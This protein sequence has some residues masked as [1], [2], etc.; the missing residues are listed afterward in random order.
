MYALARELKT[1]CSSLIR[2]A[3]KFGHHYK[4]HMS[5]VSDADEMFIKQ[6][7]KLSTGATAPPPKKE[8]ITR[9]KKA[10]GTASPA[11][12][13]GTYTSSAPPG[14]GAET[15]PAARPAEPIA[16]A[17]VTKAVITF[18]VPRAA[19]AAGGGSTGGGG[20]STATAPA[21][22][23]TGEDDGDRRG[24]GKGKGKGRDRGDRGGRDDER[25]A[26]RG[27]F[28]NRVGIQKRT[29]IG[30]AP[31]AK[32]TQGPTKAEIELPATVKD[33]CAAFGVKSD[34]VIQTLFQQGVM[35]RIN[36]FITRDEIE[37]LAIEF[38]VEVTIKDAQDHEAQLDKDLQELATRGIDTGDQDLVLRP[39]VVT[40]LGH[41]DH[42]KTSLLDRI[43]ESDV[44]GG[45]AGGI[46]QHIGAS[47]VFMPD[48]RSI[49][50]LDTPG[51]EAFTAMRARGAKIT[52]IVV[53]VVAAD[54]G[55]MP[56]TLE[57]IAHAK[58]ANVPI[59]VALNKSDRPE[60]NPMKVKGQLAEN[61]LTPTGDWGGDVEVIPTSAHPS[62]PFGI[63]DLLETILLQA[64][65]MELKA[66]PKR[67][68]TGAI[69]ESRKDPEEGVTATVLVRDGTLRPGDYGI[70]GNATGRVR[71]MFDDKGGVVEAAGPGTPVRVLG[72]EDP[73]EPGETF[74]VGTADDRKTMTRIATQKWNRTKILDMAS[75]AQQRSQTGIID[76]IDASKINEVR[77]VVKADTQGSCE[78]LKQVLNKLTGDE[79]RVNLI[80]IAVG[81]ITESDVALAATP[82]TSPTLLVGFHVIADPKAA[83]KADQDGVTMRTFRVIYELTAYIKKIMEGELAPE[84]IEVTL[85]TAE[86]RKT[87]FSSKVGT[88]AGCIVQK[89]TVNRNSRLRIY[90][91]N[92]EISPPD[93]YGLQS[94]KRLNDDAREVRE[95]MECGMVIENYDGVQEGDILR[96]FKI[97]EKARKFDD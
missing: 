92:I 86:V 89:G 40:M 43:R 48:G 85:A 96:F 75:K 87:F 65:V 77:L 84:E 41:V 17:K 93:G 25:G 53:L 21:P 79:V 27:R 34:R 9:H 73:P 14:R 11:A 8:I 50:F 36:D 23:D 60:A 13:S 54:D 51:H 6:A 45:E 80:H 55:V 90:R 30:S 95:G 38:E 74:Y 24:K 20:G 78:V 1:D 44:A 58:A 94:L 62:K 83:A 2:M 7:Y 22:T 31:Q 88:I 12:A 15:R 70:A 32:G 10:S 39:P 71:V 56:T 64:E 57:A 81:G 97:E 91:Q 72:L 29:F 52:D 47:Q 61:G 67:R 35:K 16:E 63:D 46:T 66:N 5:V 42:G 59:I 19:A 33:V 76:R 69:I 82:S 26:P 3:R 68:A 18:G 37:I 28:G 49:T 4:S